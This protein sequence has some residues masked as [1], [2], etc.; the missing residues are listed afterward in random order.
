MEKDIWTFPTALNVFP[1]FGIID[2][3]IKKSLKTQILISLNQELW[4]I[5]LVPSGTI[6]YTSL[7]TFSPRLKSGTNIWSCN[8]GPFELFLTYSFWL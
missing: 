5:Y 4:S 8:L 1:F 2:K 7:G 6:I 3:N